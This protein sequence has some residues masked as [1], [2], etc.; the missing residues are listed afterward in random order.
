MELID[1]RLERPTDTRQRGSTFLL[2]LPQHRIV[3]L[4]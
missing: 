4:G 2:D 3:A 1:E